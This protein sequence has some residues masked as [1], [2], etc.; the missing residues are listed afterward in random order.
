MVENIRLIENVRLTENEDTRSKYEKMTDQQNHAAIIKSQND[1]IAA[2]IA[3]QV[4]QKNYS[5]L[6]NEE[7][8]DTK[9]LAS[10][11]AEETEQ[12]FIAIDN[13]RRSE[14]GRAHV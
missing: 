11:S 1:M 13:V 8:E 2:W 7:N 12:L 3:H 6:Q 14:I 4:T 10:F 9:F 5:R